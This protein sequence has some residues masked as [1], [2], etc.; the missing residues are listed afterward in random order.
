MKALSIR[1][2]WAWL[3]VNGYKNI[4]NRSRS[5]GDHSGPLLIHA[6]K[7]FAAKDF[8]DCYNWLV[9]NPALNHMVHILPSPKVC[10]CHLGGIVGQV[11]VVAKIVNIPMELM[12]PDTWYTGKVGYVFQ[13]AKPL[14]FKR[15]KGQLGF[16]E[17]LL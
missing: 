1:Q 4:E 3:V 8:V 16:F 5:L 14:P 2:P 12:Q 13:D 10:L 11:N 7:S 6:S 17:V 15:C 9:E